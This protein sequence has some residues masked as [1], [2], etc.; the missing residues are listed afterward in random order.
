MKF[1]SLC[2]FSIAVILSSTRAAP[3]DEDV[4][5]LKETIK[6]LQVNYLIDCHLL[7]QKYIVT[8]VAG[9]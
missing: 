9:R 6:I 4:H 8:V 3:V 5:E 1:L 2:V 7:N